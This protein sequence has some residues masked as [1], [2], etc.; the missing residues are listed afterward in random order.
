MQDQ[1][2]AIRRAGAVEWFSQRVIRNGRDMANEAF[3][4]S[5]ISASAALPSADDYQAI[6]DAFMETS[7]GRWFLT[8]Y[9]RR[10]RNADTAMVLEAVARIEASIAT[11]KQVAA[12]ATQA[13]TGEAMRGFVAQASSAASGA[14]DRFIAAQDFTPTQRG[15]RIIRE[16][17]WRLREV[18]YDSRI[19]DILETQADT[20]GANHDPSLA[21]ALRGAV[22][23]TFETLD[24]RIADLASGGSAA[25]EAPPQA[26]APE[27]ARPPA[28]PDPAPQAVAPEAF[29]P[30]AF[31]PEAL[32]PKTLAPEI[33]TPESVAPAPSRDEVRHERATPQP[34][35]DGEADDVAAQAAADLVTATPPQPPEIQAVA[36]VFDPHPAATAMAQPDPAEVA[37]VLST[38][39]S[40]AE[41]AYSPEPAADPESDDVALVEGERD[42]FVAPQTPEADFDTDIELD[43]KL[44][45]AAAA[46]AVAA[47][48]P[49]TSQP[50]PSTPSSLIPPNTLSLGGSLLARGM[51]T[52][53]GAKADPLTP[54]RRMSQAEKIAFFS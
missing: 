49:V 43:M 25:A 9:A 23:S 1:G 21:Q 11:Q 30:E 34:A 16:V 17:A 31:A 2:D 38:A 7:R 22:L 4:L 41:T 15:L 54:I 42:E 37:E 40:P 51:V 26:T 48:A 20:I 52:A 50:A 33:Q 45:L 5:P 10:N 53:P 36:P 32:A 12:S 27:A 14:F 18:G 24:R 44:D 8:E 39:L 3:A 35:F 13:E 28:A 19:C 46:E 6:S 29:A 47:P